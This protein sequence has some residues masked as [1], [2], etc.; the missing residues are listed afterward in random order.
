MTGSPAPV[1]LEVLGKHGFGYEFQFGEDADGRAMHESW[2]SIATLG[3]YFSGFLAPLIIRAFPWIMSL[4]VKSLQAQGDTKMRVHRLGKK[5]VE[6]RRILGNGAEFEGS[7]LLS[8]LMRL[9]R[10]EPLDML[11]DQV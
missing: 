1:T 7:D 4:P 5:V 6:S 2:T 3:M 8:T 10:D 9:N 11:L